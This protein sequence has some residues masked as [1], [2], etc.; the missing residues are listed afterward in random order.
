MLLLDIKHLIICIWHGATYA[1][2]QAV[3]IIWISNHMKICLNFVREW[4]YVLGWLWIQTYS[5]TKCI[6][7]LI[8]ILLECKT[9][10]QKCT[11]SPS[12]SNHT[13]IFWFF[14]LHLP[15]L[16]TTSCVM[17]R[18]IVKITTQMYI[19]TSITRKYVTNINEYKMKSSI[20]RITWCMC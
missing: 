7:W 6:R 5:S 10:K 15:P 1:S 19:F 2:F 14:H 17:E 16:I 9:Y 12:T 13:I 3:I 4:S 8:S 18:W 20:P 11:S